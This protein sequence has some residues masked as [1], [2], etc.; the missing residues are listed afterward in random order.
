MEVVT[1]QGSSDRDGMVD[2]RPVAEASAL[3]ADAQALFDDGRYVEAAARCDEARK[4]FAQ[5]RDLAVRERVAYGLLVKGLSLARLGHV[6]D[7]IAV[8]EG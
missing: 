4:R 3:L 5:E 7:A 8:Y 1:L 2:G 6:D